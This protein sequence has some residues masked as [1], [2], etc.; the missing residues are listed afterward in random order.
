MR[1]T[2]TIPDTLYN[3]YAHHSIQQKISLN[4]SFLS[5]LQ[6]GPVIYEEE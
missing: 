6:Q 2:I 5:R 1:T 3:Q 4:Q